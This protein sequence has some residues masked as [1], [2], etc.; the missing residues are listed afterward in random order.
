MSEKRLRQIEARIEG[1]K[2]ELSKL[3]PVLRP[4]TLT[5]QYANP[6]E[7]KGAYWQVSYT[8]NMKSKTEYVKPDCVS[9]VRNQIAG[10]KKLRKLVDEWVELGLEASK[11]IMKRKEEK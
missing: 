8:R 4:G 10:Y 1:I 3:P 11:L 5:R 6:S 9:S 2:A 7:R